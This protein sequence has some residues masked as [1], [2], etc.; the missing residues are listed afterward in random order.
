MDVKPQWADVR[1]SVLGQVFIFFLKGASISFAT[2]A[3]FWGT[4]RSSPK[5]RGKHKSGNT[6]CY[7]L[8]Q[9]RYSQLYFETPSPHLGA[10]VTSG[11]VM[12]SF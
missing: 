9:E 1:S 5:S 2:D 8:V 12:A 7:I 4:L 11:V 10:N 3:D 6:Q